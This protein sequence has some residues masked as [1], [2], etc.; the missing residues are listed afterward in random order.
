MLNNNPALDEEMRALEEME[1]AGAGAEQVAQRA[2]ELRNKLQLIIDN[3]TAS[4]ELTSQS[5]RD[6]L[7]KYLLNPNHELGKDK[8]EWFKQALSYSRT[9]MEALE[10]QIAFDPTRAVQTTVTQFGTK[11]DQ[12]ISIIGANGRSINVVFSWIRTHDGVIRLITGVPTRKK[13]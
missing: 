8:A 9:N 13:K 10:R 1:K 5:I 6:K 12:T 2:A 7:Y 3:G 4:S 11:F